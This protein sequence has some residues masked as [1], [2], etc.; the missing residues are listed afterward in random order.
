V[1]IGD[2]PVTSTGDL[3]LRPDQEDL[4]KKI[5]VRKNATGVTINEWRYRTREVVTLRS[6][7]HKKNI[8]R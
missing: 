5:T 1:S 3:Q 8:W 4:D 6:K 2:V 7:E